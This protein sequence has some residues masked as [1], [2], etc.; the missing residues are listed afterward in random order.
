MKKIIEF[1]SGSS[2]GQAWTGTFLIRLLVGWIFIFAGVS[3][4]L[5]EQMGAGRFADMG[6]PMPEFLGPW[7]A[8][9]EVL[10]GVLV[11]LGLL[12][13]AGAIPLIVIMVV[14]IWVTKVPLFQESVAEGLQAARLDVSLLLASLYL[15]IAGG[16]KFAL[17]RFLRKRE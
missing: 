3:K 6:L 14:A 16:G 5:A 13:R 1:L 8:F 17:D 11:L 12:T 15:L 10:G 7:V 2:P 9:W 4:F